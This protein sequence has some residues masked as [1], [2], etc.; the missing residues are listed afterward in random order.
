MWKLQGH[1]V[2]VF[3]ELPESAVQFN[4]FHAQIIA[5]LELLVNLPINTTLCHA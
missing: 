4:Y 3:F 5:G 2:P 1:C